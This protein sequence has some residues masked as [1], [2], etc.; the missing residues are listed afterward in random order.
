MVLRKRSEA[1]KPKTSAEERTLSLPG[2]EPKSEA[3]PKPQLT[4]EVKCPA[5]EETVDVSRIKTFRPDQSGECPECG[6]VIPAKLLDAKTSPD[7][8]I[9]K[10]QDAALDSSRKKKYCG[11]CGAPMIGSVLSCDHDLSVQPVSDPSKAKNPPT[12]ESEE[13]KKKKGADLQTLADRDREKYEREREKEARPSSEDPHP[14]TPSAVTNNVSVTYDGK[15]IRCEWNKSTFNV[16]MSANFA[17][18][19]FVASEECKP[20]DRVQVANRLMDDLEQIATSAFKR[21]SKWY[22]RMLGLM[23]KD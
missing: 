17:V 14:P 3:K 11:E 18:G 5:C 9:A 22:M 20:E 6:G 15:Y 2:T 10:A 1:A 16:G 8:R 23:P 21:Q 19:P 13:R 7:A 12:R 4:G